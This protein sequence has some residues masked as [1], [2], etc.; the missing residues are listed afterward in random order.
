MRTA[1]R[2]VPGVSMGESSRRKCISLGEF[3]QAIDRLVLVKN[4]GTKLQ[5]TDVM[6]YVT[7]LEDSMGFGCNTSD[8]VSAHISKA[9]IAFANLLKSYHQC[10]CHW[11]QK[12]RV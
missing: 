5:E 3:E 2:H 6:E 7:H 12:A 1:E 4:D 9:S 8:G 11:S 10:A